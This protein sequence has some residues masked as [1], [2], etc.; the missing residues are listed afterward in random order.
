[1]RANW[2]SGAL[3]TFLFMK[4]CFPHMKKNR[5][6]RIINTCS[7]AGHGYIPGNAGYGSAKEAIRSL[8]RSAA[9]EWGEHN[10]TV[11]AIAP[12][13]ITPGSLFA[14]DGGNAT[15]EAC[16][17]MFAIKRWGDPESDIGRVVVFLSGPDASYV[18]GDTINV[19]GGMAPLV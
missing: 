15:E 19:N 17:S 18:T 7:S 6:G 2:E 8:T 14:M 9:K 12:A 16:L 4:A 11:N 3:G 13:A 1:M 10:I 5:F